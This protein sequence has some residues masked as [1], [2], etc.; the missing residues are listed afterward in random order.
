MDDYYCYLKK[1]YC[2]EVCSNE[3]PHKKHARKPRNW[4]SRAL[5]EIVSVITGKDSAAVEA[6]ICDFSGQGRDKYG[7]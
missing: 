4:F 6:G 5:D 1:G 7:R 3:C 2:L